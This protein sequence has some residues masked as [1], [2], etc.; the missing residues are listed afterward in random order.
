VLEACS[1]EEALQ[2]AET[3][4]PDLAVLDVMLP[5]MDG[6]ELCRMFR[7]KHRDTAI[8]MLTARGQDMDKLMGLE[9]GADDYMVKPFNPAELVARIRAVLRRINRKDREH[10]RYLVSGAF[11]L[12]TTAQLAYKNGSEVELTPREYLLVKTFLENPNI[13]LSREEILDKAWGRDFFGEIKTVDVHIRRLREKIEEDS[14]NPRFI[15]TVW[16][17]GYRWRKES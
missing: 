5:G 16:G 11:T 8:I 7:E 10:S 14:A 9:L 6:F 2:K 3:N 17:Y 12:D 4:I 1:A 13:A 15:E